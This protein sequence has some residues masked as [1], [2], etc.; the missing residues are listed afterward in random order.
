MAKHTFCRTLYVVLVLYL[1]D[2]MPVTSI[3][4]GPNDVAEQEVRKSN[5]NIIKHLF[6]HIYQN[7][8]SLIIFIWQENHVNI[9][10]KISAARLCWCLRFGR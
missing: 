1:L 4:F 6:M 3:V 7:I 10:Y 2:D 9:K 8:C 5:T